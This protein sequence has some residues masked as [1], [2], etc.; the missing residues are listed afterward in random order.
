MKKKSKTNIFPPPFIYSTPTLVSPLPFPL[1]PLD[2]SL[3]PSPTTY[4]SPSLPSL[5]PHPPTHPPSSLPTFLPSVPRPS[6]PLPHSPQGLSHAHHML[7]RDC[8]VIAPR[9]SP[10][11]SLWPCL[12]TPGVERGGGAAKCC[13]RPRFL[14]SCLLTCL[15]T[16]VFGC[17]PVGSVTYLSAWK[18]SLVTNLRA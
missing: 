6:H 1:F 9:Q 17:L 12:R 2:L 14:P 13:S 10:S 11:F 15:L 8:P 3:S 16:C 18:L 4:P 5:A 7:P